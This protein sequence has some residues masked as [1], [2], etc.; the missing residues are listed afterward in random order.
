MGHMQLSKT[1]IVPEAWQDLSDEENDAKTAAIYD[2]IAKHGGDVKVVA[3]APADTTLF[4]V[5]EYP[6][7]A[8]AQRSVAAILALQT[9]EFVSIETLW[10]V[11]EW[12][13]MVR[14]ANA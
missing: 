10:D 4:S 13:T 3:F 11:G 9:L 7:L 5:I 1:R 8:S 2:L 12:V 14:E 6:D